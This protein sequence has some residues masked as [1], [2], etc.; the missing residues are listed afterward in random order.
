MAEAWKVLR[1]CPGQCHGKKIRLF[2]Q[3]WR[4]WTFY[5]KKT[6]TYKNSELQKL[7]LI[8]SCLIREHIF[9]QTP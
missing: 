6:K 8:L 9:S 2:F 4:A 5:I 3:A 7:D 1:P